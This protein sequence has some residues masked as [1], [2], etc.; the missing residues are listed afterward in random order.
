MFC[1]AK[2]IIP[3]ELSL[4]FHLGF[5]VSVSGIDVYRWCESVLR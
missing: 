5:N 2:N 3:V 4:T 1:E